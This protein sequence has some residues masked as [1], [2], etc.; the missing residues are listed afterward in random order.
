V[1]HGKGSLIGKM[2]GDVW[3]KFAN[4]RLLFGYMFTQP[5]KKLLFMGGELGQFREWNHDTSLDWHLLDFP[6]HSGLQRWVRDLNA[7]YRRE[8]AL[9]ELDFSP[10]GFEWIDANDNANSVLSYIR[11]CRSS[12]GEVVVV[13]NCTPTP[14]GGYQVGVPGAGRWREVLNSDAVEYGGSGLGNLGGVLASDQPFH[15][16]PHSIV[17]TLPPLSVIMLREDA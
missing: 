16:R 9:H 11:R 3:Q 4:L 5:G 8:N 13:C 14:R 12:G 17:L 6:L 7:L 1:V 15:G 2:P 10:E